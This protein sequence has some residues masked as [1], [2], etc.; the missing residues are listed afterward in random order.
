M[1]VNPAIPGGGDP[2][3]RL[4]E[5]VADLQRRLQA[6]E[7]KQ[8]LIPIVTP[9]EFIALAP[10]V[11]MHVVVEITSNLIY[12]SFRCASN[13]S[14]QYLW[15]FVG[16]APLTDSGLLGRETTTST[17]YANL[18]TVGPDVT[19][20]LDGWYLITVGATFDTTGRSTLMSW[21]N[22]T[23]G[24]VATDNKAAGGSAALS[25][26]LFAMERTTLSGADRNN[27]IRGKYRVTGGTG[28]YD[29][30]NISLLPLQCWV[31]F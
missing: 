28:G 2:A 31:N 6:L 9:T 25:T 1:P 7:V 22:V 5:Q 13:S 26:E 3:S 16:G 21:E 15:A 12:W 18:A 19:V 23:R 20:P 10:F 24:T 14:P 17:T 4:A 29:Q 11:G 8:Q 27:V 30:R